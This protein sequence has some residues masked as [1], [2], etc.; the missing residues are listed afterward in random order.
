M[1]ALLVLIAA[2]S[3]ADCSPSPETT[4]VAVGQSP[5]G[6]VSSGLASVPVGVV[7]GFQVKANSSAVITAAIDDDTVAAV[8]PTTEASEFVVIGTV[9]GQTTLHVFVDNQEAI[10]LPV[11][12]TAPA[13]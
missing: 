10:Q 1:R 11:Q 8:A 13:P 7:L 9:T 4:I 12:V 5:A 6:S 3:V 2:V